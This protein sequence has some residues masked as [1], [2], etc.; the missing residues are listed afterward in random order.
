MSSES[1]ELPAGPRPGEAMPE[2]QLAPG[3]HLTDWI[4]P[5]FT[6]LALNIDAGERSLA[7][8]IEAAPAGPLKPVL[9][10]LPPGPAHDDVFAALGAQHGAVYLLRPD[11]HVA[12]RWRRVPAG[13]LVR[14]LER[15]GASSTA[16]ETA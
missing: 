10:T 3:L 1:D 5:A 2:Q 7:D 15:A 11:G 13:A 4:G 16:K 8:E 6:V 12:A 9:R 14:A